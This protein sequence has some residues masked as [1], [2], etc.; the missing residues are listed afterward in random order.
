MQSALSLRLDEL[1]DWF[2]DKDSVIVAFSGGVDSTLL[3]KVAHLTLKD[4]TVAVTADS[5]SL[6]R[7]ELEEAKE[8]AHKIGI[9]HL[10][11]KTH[12]LENPDYAKN[13]PDRCYYCK[14]ELF[15]ELKSL[16]VE[17][18]I[19]TIVDGTN[20]DDLKGHRPG[21]R[22]EVDEGIRRPFAELGFRKEAI[23]EL[24]RNLG[25]P[26]AD[27]PSMAC[28][29]SRFAYGQMITLSGL[30]KVEKAEK[31]VKQITGVRQLRIRNHGEIAR[32]E[33]AREEMAKLF[34]SKITAKIDTELKALGFT[35][36]TIDLA[37]YS[38][39]SMNRTIRK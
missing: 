1:L 35:Y 34:D 32:I 36:V 37:G 27:K 29:S 18:G 38:T 25:L 14:K 17:L 23:R 5:P 22:A 28:L 19:A 7:E 11:I 24:S 3:A 9:R 6:P 13:L 30:S 4:K 15:V 16:A 33:V 26:T 31:F 8:L 39:G 10:V 20:S 12:E 2:S 21:A